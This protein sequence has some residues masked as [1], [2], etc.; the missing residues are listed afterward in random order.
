MRLPR[1]EPLPR[2]V[3]RGAVDEVLAADGSACPRPA[4]PAGLEVAVDLDHGRVAEWV[5]PDEGPASMLS[6]WAPAHVRIAAPWLIA[7]A[8]SASGGEDRA[9]GFVEAI[10]ECGIRRRRRA[11][12]P[13]F[14][15]G[16]PCTEYLIDLPATARGSDRSS[17]SPASISRSPPSSTG[18]RPRAEVSG[19]AVRWV[20]SSE[21]T[22]IASMV[23]CTRAA[24]RAA[25]C[26]APS[27]VSPGPGARVATS[28]RT[29]GGSLS[30]PDQQQLHTFTLRPVASTRVPKWPPPHRYSRGIYRA[31]R[32]SGRS[33]RRR[34]STRCGAGPTGAPSRRSGRA[35]PGP[36]AAIAM[37]TRR[38]SGPD[39]S[40][41]RRPVTRRGTRAEPRTVHASFACRPAAARAEAPSCD[42]CD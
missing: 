4:R 35:P 19:S 2:G 36:A 32:R 34:P 39:R 14:V 22:K 33:V 42:V 38:A 18:G 29:L 7:T 16:G 5:G 26:R 17:R 21:D 3:G 13:P 23:R 28:P 9:H 31:R 1:E 20:R 15:A 6:A 12:F 27:G 37:R 24:G 10:E 30:V 8:V 11:L 41:A 25:A 40:G